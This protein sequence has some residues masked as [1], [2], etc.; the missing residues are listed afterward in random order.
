M[1]SVVTVP[2]VPRP[3]GQNCHRAR[4]A[5]IVAPAPKRNTRLLVLAPLSSRSRLADCCALPWVRISSPSSFSAADLR[6]VATSCPTAPLRPRVGSRL[7]LPT[8]LDQGWLAASAI[9]DSDGFHH[10]GHEDHPV[11]AHAGTALVFNDV[12]ESL[13]LRIRADDLEL[14]DREMPITVDHTGLVRH[15]ATRLVAIAQRMDLDDRDPRCACGP[16]CL[17]DRIDFV[18][19]DIRSDFLHGGASR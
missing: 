2:A 5:T 1:A 15:K 12:D 10:L 18:T 4:P 6:S 16:K 14:H 17:D 9:A 19:S 8:L 11:A 13:E 7:P 3:V